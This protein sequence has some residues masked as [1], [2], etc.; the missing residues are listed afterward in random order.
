M[1]LLISLFY[2]ISVTGQKPIP[3]TVLE[4]FSKIEPN[5]SSPFWEYRE[6]AYVAMFS[7]VD[8]LKKMFFN[9]KGEWIETRTRIQEQYLPLGVKRFINEHYA[10]ADL[11]YIGRVDQP[12]NT[13][14]RVESEF[15]TSVVIKLISEQGVLLK[16]NK[17]DYSL[18]PN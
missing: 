17:Y 1:F 18:N 16:E 9:K 8:G 15:S 14:Y 6:G 2:A 10:E 4:A 7:H 3:S 11:T 12:K 13:F 5:Q